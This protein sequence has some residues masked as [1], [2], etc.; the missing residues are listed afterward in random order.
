M[1]GCLGFLIVAVAIVA[2]GLWF[3]APPLAAVLVRGALDAGGFTGRDTAVLVVADPPFD[4]IGGHAD[5]VVLGADD[6]S[7]GSLQADRLDLTLFDVELLARGI[8]R[9]DGRLTGVSVATGDG[10]SVPAQS[11]ELLGPAGAARTTVR[12]S[13]PAI[14]ALARDAIRGRIGLPVGRLV[15][16]APDRLVFTVAGTGVSGRLVVERNGDLAIAA[17]LPGSPRIVLVAAGDPL[18]YT[19]ASVD[20]GDLVLVATI[21]LEELL[22]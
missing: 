9:V 3:G 14:N 15:L 4:L 12:I 13:G 19:G 21:D 2:A 6:A 20:D 11:V 17:D 8:G 16:E 5:A 22:R 18:T 7:L 10:G 1:R